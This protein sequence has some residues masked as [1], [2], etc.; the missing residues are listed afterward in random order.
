MANKYIFS[1]LT[2]DLDPHKFKEVIENKFLS[3]PI[4]YRVL[5]AYCSGDYQT[6]INICAKKLTDKKTASKKYVYLLFL[7]RSYFELGDM[8]KLRVVCN[9]FQQYVEADVNGEKIRQNYSVMQY[10]VCYLN[11]N[12][13]QCKRLCEEGRDINK[14]SSQIVSDKTRKIQGDFNYAVACYKLGDI[15]TA[16]QIFEGI[17][18]IAPKMN[19][20]SLS[21]KYLDAVNACEHEAK[22]YPEILPDFSYILPE[23]VGSLHLR[24]INY[25]M[26]GIFLLILCFSN[27]AENN[28]NMKVSDTKLNN[29]LAVEYK[30]YEI[31]EYF[32][33][34][35]ANKP[36]DTICIVKNDLGKTDVGVVVTYDKQNTYSFIKIIE[37][38]EIGQTYFQE[39]ITSNYNIG[40][41]LYDNE[42]DIPQ[43]VYQVIEI[44]VDNSLQFFCIEYRNGRCGRYV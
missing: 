22:K 7:A 17:I 31:I 23:H 21:K 41:T 10:Y 12:F 2:Y 14:N 11:G 8:E 5:A 26:I 19:L 42:Y 37:D 3:L 35:E 9:K 24:I 32:I 29:A 28:S 18:S 43:D 44:H 6:T 38:M 13:N 20:S 40:F 1:I 34:T 15:E 27:V 33:L 25:A 39:S 16:R 36:V 4:V 30:E